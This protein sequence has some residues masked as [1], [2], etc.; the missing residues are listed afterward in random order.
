MDRQSLRGLGG[1]L[2]YLSTLPGPDGVALALT[3]GPL[4]AFGAR[5]AVLFRHSGDVLLPW[6]WSRQLPDVTTVLPPVSVG[7]PF[8]AARAC[9]ELETVVTEQ[10]EIR[11]AGAEWGFLGDLL[12]ASD[13]PS[14]PDA[15]LLTVPLIR[16]GRGVGAVMASIT[17]PLVH[18]DGPLF[19]ALGAALGLWIAYPASPANG[20]GNGTHDDLALTPRQV[21]LLEGVAAGHSTAEIAASLGF[22][23]STVKFEVSRL[24]RLLRAPNRQAAVRTAR[25]LGLLADSSV[26]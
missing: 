11:A 6:G 2:G 16:E 22:S 17:G 4:A 21:R 20:S 9:R 13:R 10:S 24:M 25:T 7:S 19:S 8:P 15:R 12:A 23:E 5:V 26:G 3:N 1:L 18:E 14:D